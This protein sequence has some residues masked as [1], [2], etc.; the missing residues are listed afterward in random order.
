VLT[1]SR[2][3]ALSGNRFTL[4]ATATDRST[5][6]IES[7]ADFSNWNPVITTDSARLDITNSTATAPLQFYRMRE[8]P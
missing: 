4:R 3:T 1:L 5:Y 7:T 2:A 6:T 8:V